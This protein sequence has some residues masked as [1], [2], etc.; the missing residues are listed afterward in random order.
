[1]WAELQTMNMTS[2]EIFQGERPWTALGDFLNY[3][4][5]YAIDRRADLIEEPVEEPENV[6]TE[7]HQ[8]AVFC[9]AAV[10]YLCAQY[11]I[12]CPE[13]VQRFAALPEPYF[14]GL[15]S[16]KPHIQARLRQEAPEAFAKRNIFCS[17]RAFANK[18]EQGEQ[19]AS[20]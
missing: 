20:A 15:G 2:Q 14:T 12:P 6:T 17:P 19:R 11:G 7:H 10:E 16:S 13:W 1:M 8:W 18:Y 9:A 5:C 4:F 3:W